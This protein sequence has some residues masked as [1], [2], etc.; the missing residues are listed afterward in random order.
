MRICAALLLTLP[1]C[2]ATAATPAQPGSAVPAPRI[3]SA[4]EDHA[5]LK[6]H[7]EAHAAGSRRAQRSFGPSI[8]FARL[9]EHRG[10]MLEVELQDGRRRSGVLDRVDA[11]AGRLRVRLGAGEYLFEF[12]R[13]EVAS[14]RGGA[15]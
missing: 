13:N 3:P 14:I 7:L 6:R 5:W 12:K 10:A 2:A 8:E 9:P 1:L 11:D 15:R 4:E